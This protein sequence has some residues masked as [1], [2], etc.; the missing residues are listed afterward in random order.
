VLECTGG[1]EFSLYK[2]FIWAVIK[3]KPRGVNNK[4]AG[5]K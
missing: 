5:K 4:T 1:L 2:L 3:T